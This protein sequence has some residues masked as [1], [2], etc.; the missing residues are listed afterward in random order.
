MKGQVRTNPPEFLENELVIA[1]LDG[2]GRLQTTA[3]L[4]GAGDMATETT[5]AALNDKIP[6]AIDI[7]GGQLIVPVAVLAGEIDA[8]QSGTWNVN[9]SNFPPDPSTNTNQLAANT[10]LDTIITA[11]QSTESKMATLEG[12]RVPTFEKNVNTT[13]LI[14]NGTCPASPTTLQLNTLAATTSTNG[15]YLTNE[16]TSINIRVGGVSVSATVGHW[17]GAGQ[18]TYLPT[19]ELANHYVSGIGGTAAISVRGAS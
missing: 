10:K 3:E 18:T 2:Y 1:T 9:I 7:G 4:V 19:L 14:G 15:W 17:L 8:K 6:D 5:L 13:P 11:V 16:S 12:G